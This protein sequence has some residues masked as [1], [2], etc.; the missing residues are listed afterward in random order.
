ME[1]PA[2]PSDAGASHGNPATSTDPTV[3][4]YPE[5][6]AAAMGSGSAQMRQCY[7]ETMKRMKHRA[8][9]ISGKA[10]LYLELLAGGGPSRFIMKGDFP[11]DLELEWCLARVVCALPFPPN[12]LKDNLIIEQRLTFTP[13]PA[14]PTT[15]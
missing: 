6:A 7:Q 14:P 3:T 11:R 5:R 8:E 10:V 1:R 12:P 4:S 9:P 2:K 13:E 15:P